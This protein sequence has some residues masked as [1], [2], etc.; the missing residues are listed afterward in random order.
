MSDENEDE[1]E[2]VLP[3]EETTDEPEIVPAKEGIDEL[4]RQLDEERA[5]RA[6][7]ERQNYEL[8][9]Q[10]HAARADKEDTD[11]QLVSNA[12]DTL[13]REQ[14]QLKRALAYAIQNNDGQRAADLQEQM[15]ENAAQLQQLRTGLSAMKERPKAPPPQPTYAD[16]VEA[17]AARLTP[18]SAEWVRAHPDYIR[19]PSL[20]RKMIAAH[21]LAVADGIVPDTDAY[22][23]ALESTLK[24]GQRVAPATPDEAPDAYAAKVARKRDAI[25]AAAPVS[26]GPASRNVIRL[27]ADEREMAEMLGMSPEKY[28]EHKAA[29]IKEGKIRQ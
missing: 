22:F 23:E 21:E 6:E 14:E 5:R 9:Q 20:N 28:G 24:I 25:P 1:I 16:P 19:N 18:R 11:I 8:A 13:D 26:R 29:L 7:I 12:I 27:T 17:F 4:K 3:E 2:I 10:A 15:G